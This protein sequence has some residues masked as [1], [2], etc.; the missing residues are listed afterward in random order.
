VPSATVGRTASGVSRLPML[1]SIWSG[2]ASYRNN[3]G[4]PHVAQKP[5]WATEELRNSAGA[6]RVQTKSARPIS[7]Q[8]KN[9]PPTAFWHMRQ[10][11]MPARGAAY[12]A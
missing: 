1:M 8:A 5:R 11:Q 10:W 12:S 7:A 3:S 4:V 6:P 2:L 9:G